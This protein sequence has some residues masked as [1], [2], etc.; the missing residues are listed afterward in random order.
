MRC[1]YE[2]LEIPRDSSAEDIKK[3]YKKLALKWHPDKNV[4]REEEATAHFKEI[5]TSYAVRSV[6][7]IADSFSSRRSAQIGVKRRAGAAMV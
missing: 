3:Q 7:L 5:N 1:H 2:V 4:G 6:A